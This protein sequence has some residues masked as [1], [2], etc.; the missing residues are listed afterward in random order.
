MLSRVLS[1]DL[2]A[3]SERGVELTSAGQRIDP[4]CS[5]EPFGRPLAGR[6]RATS[7]DVHG[8]SSFHKAAAE[9]ARVEAPLIASGGYGF[10]ADGNRTRTVKDRDVAD[11]LA[12][13]H[14]S[15]LGHTTFAV[16]DHEV[17]RSPEP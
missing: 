3:A 14:D 5:G 15:G 16:I 1:I 9:G 8:V 17:I 10:N 2:V 11:H 6:L 12:E 4:H 13:N 7:L